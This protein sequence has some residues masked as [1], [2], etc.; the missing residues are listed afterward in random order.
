MNII[1]TAAGQEYVCTQTYCL[2]TES[3]LGSGKPERGGEGEKE[4]ERNR[5]RE[6]GREEVVYERK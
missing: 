3:M 1:L 5:E 6:G 4:R 2:Y